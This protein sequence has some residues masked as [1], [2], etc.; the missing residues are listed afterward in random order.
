M[1]KI[2]HPLLILLAF[3][4]LSLFIALPPSPFAQEKTKPRGKL[5]VVNMWGGQESI[6]RNCLEG[7]VTQDKDGKYVPCL[8]QGWKWID[9][10]TIEFRLRQGVTFHD[11]E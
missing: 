3:I 2:K 5:I 1:E 4:F 7:L 11:G 8:A 10:R 6:Y 9:D